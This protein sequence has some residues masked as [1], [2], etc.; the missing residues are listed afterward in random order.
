LAIIHEGRK[1][2]DGD[3]TEVRKAHF[4]KEY[5]LI[6]SEKIAVP[7]TYHYYE[8]P[9]FRGYQMRIALAPDQTQEELLTWAYC[10]KKLNSF[11]DYIPTIHEIFVSQVSKK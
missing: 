1:V 11:N 2:L 4:K 10:T 7:E 8:I 5:D 3:I 9:S 6:F